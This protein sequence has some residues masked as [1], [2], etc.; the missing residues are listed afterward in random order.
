MALARRNVDTSEPD[1]TSGEPGAG[2][3]DCGP[4]MSTLR[5]KS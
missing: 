2:E 4:L 5:L 1:G 3:V